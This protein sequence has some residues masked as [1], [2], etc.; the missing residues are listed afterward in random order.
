MGI[1]IDYFMGNT[2]IKTN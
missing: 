1:L 2:N